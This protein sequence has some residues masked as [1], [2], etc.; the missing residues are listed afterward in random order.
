MR[1]KTF[2]KENQKKLN[3]TIRELK[4]KLK[5][6]EKER[7]FYKEEVENI[8][9]PQRDRKTHQD[10]PPE[11]DHDSWRKDFLK[12]YKREVLGEE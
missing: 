10:K 9:K 2:P 3:G 1:S 12:R 8:T 6:V 7:D 4:A 5:H 11:M